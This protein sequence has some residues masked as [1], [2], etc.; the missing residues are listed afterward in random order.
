MTIGGENNGW[1]RTGRKIELHWDGEGGQEV[2]T[3]G[4]YGNGRRN[5]HH[6]R[7]RDLQSYPNHK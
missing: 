7:I 6:E 1:K 5:R 2:G 4:E 3:Q